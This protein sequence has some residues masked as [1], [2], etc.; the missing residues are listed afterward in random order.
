MYNGNLRVLKKMRGTQIYNVLVAN[1][2]RLPAGMLRWRE[3]FEL[4]DEEMKSA[5]LFARR[6][7]HSTFDHAFQYKINSNILPTKEYLCR[8]RVVDSNICSKCNL[9]SDTVMHSIWSCAVVVPYIDKVIAF[10][11]SNCDIENVTISIKTFIFGTK[12]MGL[13][14]IF[15]ELKKELFYS[16]ELNLCTTTFCE[17]FIAKIRKLMIKEKYFMLKNEQFDAYDAKWKD[18]I[19]IYNYHGPDFEIIA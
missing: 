12:S 1:K 17:Y 5:F 16:K 6:C 4:N 3:D 14:L 10:L 15:L 11:K 2:C 18:F 19:N 9:E 8:Y 13:D 7:S